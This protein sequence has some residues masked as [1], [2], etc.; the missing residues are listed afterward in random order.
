[1]KNTNNKVNMKKIIK[2]AFAVVA[3]AAVGLGSFKAYSS[4]TAANMSEEDLLMA[5][6]V[7]ALSDPTPSNGCDQK[8]WNGTCPDR[9][10]AGNYICSTTNGSSHCTIH[11]GVAHTH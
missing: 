10:G 9:G 1:M 11:C 3:I 6:N 4:Y 2:M 5:E 7:L 8:A